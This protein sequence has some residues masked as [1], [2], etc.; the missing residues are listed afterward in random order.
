M[1]TNLLVKAYAK[2]LRLPAIARDMDKLATEASRTN[3]PYDRFVLLLL[4]QEVLQREENALKLRL[5]NA[6]FPVLKTLDT[7]EFTAAPKLNKAKILEL[8]E[9]RWI[10]AGENVVLV[11]NPGTG[12]SHCA[13]ALSIAACRKEHKVRFFT[14]ANLV[15]ALLEAQAQH[16]LS[17]LEKHLNRFDLLVIDDLGYVPFS[18][19]GAELLFGVIAARYERKS[20][21]VT[22]N[23]EF[24]A[25]TEVFG[26]ERM[27]G[28]LVDRLTH[29]CHIVAFQ[30]ESYRFRQSQKRTK[31]ASVEKSQAASMME[32]QG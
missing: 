25:W 30:G 32:S 15:N 28:A 2:R 21:L 22:T 12:K 26:S 16:G 1:E 18:K 3:L 10:D 23:L 31:G 24:S 27:T 6:C 4:E 11:G 7:F 14:A 5:K 9:C 29:K 19:A 13:V 8:A 17:R 20:V